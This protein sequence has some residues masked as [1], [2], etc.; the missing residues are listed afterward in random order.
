MC[1][2]FVSCPQSITDF[3]E[4]P[5]IIS[6]ENGSGD[7]Y[8]DDILGD[9]Q[10]PPIPPRSN[11]LNVKKPLPTIPNSESFNDFTNANANNTSSSLTTS[12]NNT[13]NNTLT[14]TNNASSATKDATNNFIHSERAGEDS[15]SPSRKLPQNEDTLNTSL[16][17]RP[18]PPIPVQGSNSLDKVNESESEVSSCD[19]DYEQIIDNDEEDDD[20]GTGSGTGTGINGNVENNNSTNNSSGTAEDKILNGL[21]GNTENE[22]FDAKCFAE[23]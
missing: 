14:T 8:E 21:N 19:E 1:C 7:G 23:G 17:N 6:T 15:S 18:L 16:S 11:S 22:D 5:K 10:P 13:T 3:E 9:E 4:V 2:F 12:A 20:L